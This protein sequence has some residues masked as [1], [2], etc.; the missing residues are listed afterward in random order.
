MLS[1][2]VLKHHA[3]LV[4]RMA[5]ALGLDLE[6]VVM[7]GRLT[8]GDLGDAVLNCHGCAHPD[9]CGKWLTNLSSTVSE[10]PRDCR[11]AELLRT[12]KAGKRW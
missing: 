12:L 2:D 5:G 6:E 11:N 1:R 4:D 8:P 3:D 9:A 10:P 7:Q